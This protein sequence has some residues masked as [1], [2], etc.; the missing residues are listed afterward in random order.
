MHVLVDHRMTEQTILQE[1]L[2]PRDPGCLK[3]AIV[4]NESSC[5]IQYDRTLR[6]PVLVL[7]GGL[8]HARVEIPC[9]GYKSLLK[10]FPQLLIILQTYLGSFD[11]FSLEVTMHTRTSLRVDLT[12]GTQ[13]NKA[14]IEDLNTGIVV[15]K[16]P[17]II[18]RNR[19]VQVVF[20][21][22]GILTHLFDL[23]PIQS[24]DSISLTGTCKTSRL[25]VC[26]DEEEAINAAPGDMALFAVPAY[27]PP[28][29]QTAADIATPVLTSVSR[30]TSGSTTTTLKSVGNYLPVV[31]ETGN[32][33]RR[34]PFR[35]PE[36]TVKSNLQTPPPP[37]ER[38]SPKSEGVSTVKPPSPCEPLQDKQIFAPQRGLLGNLTPSLSSPSKSLQLQPQKQKQQPQLASLSP[39]SIQTQQNQQDAESHSTNRNVSYIRLVNQTNRLPQRNNNAVNRIRPGAVTKS[40]SSASGSLTPASAP[41]ATSAAPTLSNTA[42]TWCGIT[43]WGE[44]ID[45]VSGTNAALLCTADYA[46]K[47]SLHS[48]QGSLGERGATGVNNK[49]QKTSETQNLKTQQTKKTME[50]RR[51]PI[52]FPSKRRKGVGG[53]T[54]SQSFVDTDTGNGVTHSTRRRGHVS[55]RSRIRERIRLLKEAQSSA[56]RIHEMKKLTA[57]ELPIDPLEEAQ[58]MVNE[59]IVDFMNEPRCGYGFGYLGV[60]RERG[61]F[62]TDE[63]VDTNLK[64]ALTLDISGLSEDEEDGDDERE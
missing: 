32:E 55:R 54:E 25:M 33:K 28:I 60:L 40:E 27:A 1:V 3:T 24:L 37:I 42:D 30:T 10:K 31:G 51:R 35:Q 14:T 9:E 63:G 4:Q 17:L 22:S 50:L 12:I 36:G 43:G 29:W 59:E 49:V 53:G 38:N 44:A 52:F 62:E 7:R 18:P 64:G 16:M 23:P 39:K 46:I 15:A 11:S 2:V 34:N 20:H 48:I 56:R 8:S 57:S 47:S 13:F 58:M 19:W 6:A 5:A 21:V 41:A 45:F 61:G 26:N